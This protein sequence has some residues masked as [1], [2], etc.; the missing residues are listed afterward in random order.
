MHEDIRSMLH[1]YSEESYQTCWDLQEVELRNVP[2]PSQVNVSM[3]DTWNRLL[4]KY[5][6]ALNTFVF[7]NSF[8]GNDYFLLRYSAAQL[9]Q[10]LQVMEN[11][12]LTSNQSDTCK[13]EIEALFYQFIGCIYNIKEKIEVFFCW[14]SG[15]RNLR[16]TILTSA[17]AKSALRIF[18]ELYSNIADY[19]NARNACIHNTYA[20][21]YLA[22]KQVFH[23]SCFSFTLSARKIS[24]EE[25]KRDKLNITFP[26]TLIEINRVVSAIHNALFEVLDILSD[27][28]NIQVAKLQDK[29]VRIKDG[30]KMIE[31]SF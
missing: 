23:V 14:E 24:E 10:Y 8:I 20:L 9:N 7:G 19:C 11:E 21:D 28:E 18:H 26:A 22:E 29:F 1:K 3:S 6:W 2:I 5:K 25:K 4:R 31:I 30:K 13:L 27:L 12:E 15:K 17:G 16:D